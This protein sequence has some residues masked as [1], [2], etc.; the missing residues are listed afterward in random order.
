MPVP[1]QAQLVNRGDLI[2]TLPTA[3]ARLR[4]MAKVIGATVI[5]R[6]DQVMTLS[7]DGKHVE[8]VDRTAFDATH[9]ISE[10]EPKTTAPAPAVEPGA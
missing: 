1:V 5:S 4:G 8:L 10:S 6:H 9:Q 3:W 7:E 2:A